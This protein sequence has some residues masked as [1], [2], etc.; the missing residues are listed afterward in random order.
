MKEAVESLRNLLHEGTVVVPEG[1]TV[2]LREEQCDDSEVTLSELPDDTLIVRLDRF[3][4]ARGFLKNEKGECGR[5][6]FLVLTVYK[7]RSFAL[8]LEMK[9][10]KTEAHKITQQ[11][12]GGWC[13]FLYLEALLEKFHDK[14]R[15]AAGFRTRFAACRKTKLDKRPIRP[16]AKLS[17]HDRPEKFAALSRHRR[18]PLGYLL[19]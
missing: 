19:G 2:T 14:R 6:D 10:G 11:L 13:V 9:R 4:D 5:C 12:R 3:P 15:I 8:F 1:R 17:G 18:I 7:G 16:S